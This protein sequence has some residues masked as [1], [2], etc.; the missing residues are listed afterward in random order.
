MFADR[1]KEALYLREMTQRELA[2]RAGLTE[3]SV[4]RYCKGQREPRFSVAVKMAKALNVSTEFF[5]EHEIDKEEWA[6]GVGYA[7]SP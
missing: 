6:S 1:L 7:F 2:R 4:T 3:A 5:V